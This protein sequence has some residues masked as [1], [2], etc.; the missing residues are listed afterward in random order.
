MSMVPA[1]SALTAAA[2]PLYGMCS[3]S[4]PATFSISALP[5]CGPP[6]I[7]DVPYFTLPGLALA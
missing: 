7:P 2:T 4:T 6:P 1:S 3:I 5:M